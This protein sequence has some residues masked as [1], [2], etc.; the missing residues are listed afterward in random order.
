MSS[1]Q[2]PPSQLIDITIYVLSLHDKAVSFDMRCDVFIKDL[3]EASVANKVVHV[4][5]LEDMLLHHFLL[6]C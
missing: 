6:V 5:Y 1:N 4:L 2:H 3:E